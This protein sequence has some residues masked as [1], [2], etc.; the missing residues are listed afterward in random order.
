MKKNK[1]VSRQAQK[2]K[3]FKQHPERNP[4][5]ENITKI[6]ATYLAQN[7]PVISMDTKKKE[8]IGNFYRAGK[9]SHEKPLRSWT[10][11]LPAT[12]RARL[13]RTDFMTWG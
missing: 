3:S 7:Q 1:F 2:K 12:A 10:M 9:L 13:C 5:F 4:Q 11:I 6:K 8:M